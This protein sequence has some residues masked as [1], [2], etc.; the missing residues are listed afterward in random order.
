MT[1]IDCS[2]CIGRKPTSAPISTATRMSPALPRYSRG[3]N[4]EPAT[5]SAKRTASSNVVGASEEFGRRRCLGTIT[6]G[7]EIASMLVLLC[8]EVY[9]RE[10]TVE[11]PSCLIVGPRCLF[12]IAEVAEVDR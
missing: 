2:A 11:P 3:Q 5:S 8:R 4:D 12:L 1:E 9:P 7:T 10:G 6:V